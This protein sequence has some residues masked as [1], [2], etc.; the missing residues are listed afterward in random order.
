[1]AAMARSVQDRPQPQAIGTAAASAA[2]GTSTNTH[3]AITAAAGLRPSTS[4]GPPTRE[5]SRTAVEVAEVMPPCLPTNVGTVCT[6]LVPSSIGVP[7]HG[8]PMHYDPALTMPV[9]GLPVRRR[10]EMLV[11]GG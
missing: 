6:L 9:L 8:A 7:D 11:T 5:R 3:I 4:G 1:M 2:N 10:H